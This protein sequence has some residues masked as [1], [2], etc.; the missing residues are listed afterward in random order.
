MAQQRG[1]HQ[2]ALSH[3][4][5]RLTLSRAWPWSAAFSLCLQLVILQPIHKVIFRSAQEA[6][7]NVVE[8]LS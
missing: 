6:A 2:R 3:Y 1:P 8:T 5:M 4:L 7:T